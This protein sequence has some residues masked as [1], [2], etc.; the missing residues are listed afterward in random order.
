MHDPATAAERQRLR[1][2]VDT[3]KRAGADLEEIRRREIAA[4]DTREAVR[5]V[6]AFSDALLRSLPPRRSSG[7]VEQQAW[8]A[9]LRP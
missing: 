5:Q 7:L 8:F 2:W 4:A 1:E 9:K 6:F 3:W